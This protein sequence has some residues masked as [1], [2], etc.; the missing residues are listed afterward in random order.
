MKTL[1]RIGENKQKYIGMNS[2]DIFISNVLDQ[3]AG[4]EGIIIHFMF[5]VP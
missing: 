5:I 3:L 4:H 1:S 2:V